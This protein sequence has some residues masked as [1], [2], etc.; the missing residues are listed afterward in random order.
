MKNIDHR[1]YPNYSIVLD[2]IILA[3]F[4]LM[5]KLG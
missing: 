5:D 1:H 3:I 2:L 4:L